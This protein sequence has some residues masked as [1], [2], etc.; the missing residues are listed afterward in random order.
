[1]AG[2]N[3]AEIEL[4][5]STARLPAGL[6]A[7]LKMIEG[8]AHKTIGILGKSTGDKDK[9]RDVSSIARG[10]A[11][12][13]VASMLAVRGIDMLV[14]AGKEVFDFNKQLVRFGLA[15]RIGGAELTAFG[16]S[17]RQVAAETGIAAAEV[18]RGERAYVDLAGAENA[19]AASMRTIARTAQATGADVG[20]M[21]TV[22]YSLQNALHIPPGD[23]ENV[24]GGIINQSK[25]GTVH[26]QQMAQ[27]IIALSPIYARFGKTGRE[28]AV[29]MGAQLQIVRSGF[30][31]ASEAAVGLKN[32]WRNLQL[33][34]D[35]FEKGGVKIFNTDAAG[36]KTLRPI[37]E[38]LHDI[39]KAKLNF[40][41]QKLMKAFGRG[42]SERAYRLLTEQV[43]KLHE[44]EQAGLKDGVVMQDLGTYTESAGGRMEI[45]TEKMK[46]A[47]AEA[48]TPER[49]ERF[50]QMFEGITEKAGEFA[51]AV[52]KVGEAFGAI[53]SL[54]RGLRGIFSTNSNQNP[55]RKDMDNLMTPEGQAEQGS[56]VAKRYGFDQVA[57]DVMSSLDDAQHPTKKSDMVA[58]RAIAAAQMDGFTPGGYGAQFA[59]EKYFENTNAAADKVKELV[60][61][62]KQELLNERIP[63]GGSS[64]AQD[65]RDLAQ[66]IGDQIAKQLGPQLS[67]MPQPAINL[68][69]SKVST[70]ADNA[71]VRKRRP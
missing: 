45:A 6:R 44:L 22:M 23:L 13:G 34:A 59:G 32:M 29:E 26:F 10:A 64:R 35:K 51:E 53:Y 16:M 28:G 55:W 1:M 33:H 40:D 21:A 17:A 25:D 2:V 19:S 38:I 27:E 70:G 7:G 5:A 56:Q 41:P 4:T 8:F 3:K 9:D 61:A 58:A 37:S 62:A 20:D 60:R 54:G 47:I 39:S 30:K 67:R 15:T 11:I 12:G 63:E 57:K 48:F 42:E 46:N 36:H 18:L 43:D 69:G 50:V 24:M 68:D 52:G 31:D 71:S 66:M 49:I 65:N 14:G